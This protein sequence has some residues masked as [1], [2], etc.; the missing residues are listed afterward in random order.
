MPTGHRQHATGHSTQDAGHRETKL[1]SMSSR[2]THWHIYT[3][4]VGEFMAATSGR[5][6]PARYGYIVNDLNAHNFAE[7][8][9]WAGGR[10]NGKNT[11]TH[12]SAIKIQI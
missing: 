8:R 2:R 5:L 9:I 4:G 6:C 11:R 1:T 7:A 10:G 12:R 3:Q